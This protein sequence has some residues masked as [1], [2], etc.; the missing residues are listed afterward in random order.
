MSGVRE[1]RNKEGRVENLNTIK[2]SETFTKLTLYTC[3]TSL[4]HFTF[5][6]SKK[7]YSQEPIKAVL[8]ACSSKVTTE[9]L[10]IKH[11]VF[12][13]STLILL[14]LSANTQGEPHTACVLN[15]IMYSSI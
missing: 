2:L 10:F 13:Y 5:L 15:C 3:I 14:G 1:K 9:F 4:N 6:L 12:L 8:I 11:K 7:K